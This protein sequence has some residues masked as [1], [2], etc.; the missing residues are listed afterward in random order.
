MGNHV[1][2]G[3]VGMDDLEIDVG[4]AGL[5]GTPEQISLAAGGTQSFSLDAGPSLAGL[6]YLLLGS[7]SGTSPGIPIDGVQLPL[8]ADVYLTLSLIGPNAPPLSSSLGTLD[9][10]GKAAAAFT[11][12]PGLSPTLAGA[13]LHHAFVVVELLP[14]LLHVPYAS[15]PVPLLLVP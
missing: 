9:A 4:P 7:T 5:A 2:G 12:P 14:T 10:Q 11:L 13:Q 6:P 15:D 8:N 1:L 3:R